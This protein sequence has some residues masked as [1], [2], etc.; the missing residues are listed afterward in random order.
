[1]VMIFVCFSTSNFKQARDVIVAD[2]QALGVFDRIEVWDEVRLSQQP[3]YKNLPERLKS[4][5]GHGFFWWKP[6]IIRKALEQ[7]K[8]GDLVFYSD[9]GRYDGGFRLGR[10]LCYLLKKFASTGFVGVEVPQ[11]GPAKLWTRIE[12]VDALGVR[13]GR[14]LDLPQI[15]GTFMLWR[16]DD[17]SI[18]ALNE[19]EAACRV[20]DIVADPLPDELAAQPA[21]F[22]Q[23]RHDQS[24]LTI[25]TRKNNLKYITLGN[26]FSAFIFRMMKRS[27]V[28]NVEMKKTAFVAMG[29]RLNMPALL[30]VIKYVQSK[31]MQMT[32]SRGMHAL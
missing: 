13:D 11:F 2:A 26:R 20:P 1:M 17:R 3:E 32:G 5:R 23:H 16:H 27:A 8:P 22:F 28:A 14:M 12:C 9:C 7:T 6:F 31:L 29:L 10:G 30:M 24:V 19:W 25:I 15:Q 4:G 21:C 18:V